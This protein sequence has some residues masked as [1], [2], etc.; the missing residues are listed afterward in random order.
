MPSTT[1]RRERATCLHVMLVA[2]GLR[3]TS[4]PFDVIVNE[5]TAC[6]PQAL[7]VLVFGKL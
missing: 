4:L 1:Q 5:I 6:D 7:D 3:Y 2:T